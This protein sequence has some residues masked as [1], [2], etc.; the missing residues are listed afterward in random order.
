MK[1]QHF[2]NT[3]GWYQNKVI[4]LRTLT[5]QTSLHI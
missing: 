4:I 1:H 5:K 3:A 2:V